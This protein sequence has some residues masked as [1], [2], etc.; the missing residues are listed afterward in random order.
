V[1]FEELS[2]MSS[3]WR[4]KLQ[5]VAAWNSAQVEDVDLPVGPD[6]EFEQMLVDDDDFDKWVQTVDWP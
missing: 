1:G 2:I 3:A 5:D 6:L 4:P